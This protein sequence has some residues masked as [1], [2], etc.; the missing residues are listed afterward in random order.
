MYRVVDTLAKRLEVTQKKYV[1]RW[2]LIDK[3]FDPYLNLKSCIPIKMM[4]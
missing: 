2:S 3:S 1:V 4:F